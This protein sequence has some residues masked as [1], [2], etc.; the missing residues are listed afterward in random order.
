MPD[1]VHTITTVAADGSVDQR[2]RQRAYLIS[3]AARTVCFLG[4]IVTPSPWRW[5][6]AFGAVALPY[7]AVVVANART[8]P[9]DRF[10]P[11]SRRELPDRRGD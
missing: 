1:E 8:A 6:L 9:Q 2:R 11:V 7:F 3:M 10:T 4:A 5:V